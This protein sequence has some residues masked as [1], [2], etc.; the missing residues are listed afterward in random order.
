VAL[1]TVRDVEVVGVD[2]EA[3]A[4]ALSHGDVSREGCDRR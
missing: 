2:L 3:V 1:V 4:G